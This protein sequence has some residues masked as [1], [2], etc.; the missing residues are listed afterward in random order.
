MLE[1]RGWE[2][3]GTV[4]AAEE[5]IVTDR[6]IGI[7]NFEQISKMN[8]DL[9]YSKRPNSRHNLGRIHAIWGPYLRYVCDVT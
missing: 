7:D 9:E 2:Y 3:D 4:E 5:K 1:I 6:M 8:I